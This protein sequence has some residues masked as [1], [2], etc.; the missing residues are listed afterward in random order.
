MGKTCFVILSRVDNVALSFNGGKDCTVAFHL[1][2]AC[3]ERLRHDI[4]KIKL[5]QIK[6]VHFVKPDE[7]E[8]ISEFRAL[9][10]R[11]YSIQI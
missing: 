10:E 8:E 6:F 7:F 9:I 11:E 5:S 1:L 4:P 3:I 2:S